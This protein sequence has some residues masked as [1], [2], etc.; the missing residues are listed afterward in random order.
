MTAKS[1]DLEAVRVLAATLEPFKGDERERIIRWAREKLGMSSSTGGSSAPS[2]PSSESIAADAV[3]PLPPPAGTDIK[4]FVAQKDPKSDVHFAATVAYYHQFIAPT[5]ERKDSITKDDIV[6]ACRQVDRKR[7]RVP[8]QVLV[9]AYHDGVFDRG[10]RGHY[11]LNSV[12][13]N[14]VAMALPGTPENKVTRKRK[15]PGIAGRG[16]AKRKA[17]G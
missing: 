1:D 12:G 5:D 16:K 4:K 15:R 17:R 8:A 13:E 14:L 2:M 7:P 11:E 10:Q 6:E 9:N 3:K